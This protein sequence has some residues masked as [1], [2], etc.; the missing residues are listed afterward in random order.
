MKDH[1]P[2]GDVADRLELLTFR[3]GGRS[4]AVPIMNVR[5]IRGW[6]PPTPLPHAPA[7]MLGMVNLRGSVLPVMD[8]ARRLGSPATR[9]GPRNV[10]V[11]VA[12]E[13]RVHGLMVE[14][15]SDI[16]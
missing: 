7:Y 2:E 8:L 6:S 13:G 3:C 9:D 5:E 10:I 1:E 14:A 16:V 15:V 12:L 11:V 4:Y